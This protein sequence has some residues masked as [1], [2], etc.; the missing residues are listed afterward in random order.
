MPFLVGRSCGCGHAMAARLGRCAEARCSLRLGFSG[1]TLGSDEDREGSLPVGR[2]IRKLRAVM[3]SSHA[4]ED[5]CRNGRRKSEIG[6]R[7]ISCQYFASGAWRGSGPS[8][9]FLDV[10][11]PLDPR[12]VPGVCT[13]WN[14]E[15]SERCHLSL[16]STNNAKK[17]N[18][19]ALYQ[20]YLGT[21][22]FMVEVIM[23]DMKG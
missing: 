14:T 1:R 12:Q 3:S 7:G 17:N 23:C 2:Q 6:R 4:V 9:F 8:L 22:L 10:Q 18:I 20:T 13:Y 21:Y 5:R 19:F 16:G 15:D 11:Q